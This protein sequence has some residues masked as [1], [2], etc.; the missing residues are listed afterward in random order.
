MCDETNMS[1]STTHRR[2]IV[3]PLLAAALLVACAPREEDVIDPVAEELAANGVYIFKA[4]HSG[5][6]VDITGA[7]ALAGANVQQWDCSGRTNQQFR[8]R[9]AGSGYYELRPMNSTGMCLDVFQASMVNGGNIDQWTCNG[10]TSQ[11]W[12]LVPVPAGSGKFE[13]V[14]QNSG[15]CMDVAGVSTLRGANIQQWG[16]SGHT[17]Q[18]FTFTSVVNATSP[19]AGVDTAPTCTGETDATFCGR[20]GKSCGAVTGTDNCGKPRSVASCGTCGTGQLCGV[21]TPN[22]CGPAPTT[23]LVHPGILASKAQLDFVKGH[24]GV[25]PWKTALAQAKNSR[26][27][28]LSYIPMPI[29]TVECGPYSNPDIGCGEE[30]NDVVA[31]YTHALLWYLTRDARYAQKSIEIMNAWSAVLKA[32]TNSNAPLQSAWAASVFPR[33]AEIIK[34]TYTGWAAADQARF[35]TLLHDVYLPM[36]VNG[37]G[38]N[39][40]WELAMIEATMNI[41]VFLDDR[42]LFD[43]AVGMWR[44][45]VPAYIYLT[46]DGPLPVSPPNSSKDTQSELVSFWYGQSTFVDGLGQETCRDFGH[47]QMGFASMAAA[48][49]TA[50][51]Q[52]VDLFG[53]ESKRI[54]AGWEFA[55]QY[56]NGAPVPAWL[57]GGT[58]T[59]S[60]DPTWEIAFNHYATRL[61]LAMPQSQQVIGKVRPT[62]A[63]HHMVWETLTHAATGNLGP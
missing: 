39:G 56:L 61:G 52:G 24:L 4:V 38:A 7:S 44:K 40:N 12:K 48:A 15:L 42:A 30:K 59:L 16:C 58:L 45:R 34:H 49:E 62:G 32:H 25:E 51:I 19:D 5:K 10:H 11:R 53:A 27:G 47:L 20:L 6:C 43:K 2:A 1:T 54:R 63:S 18:L 35:A 9:D 33:A 8:L 50:R 29:A 26:F 36:V 57:C 22:V 14:A 60:Y 46:T 55:A 21:A 31:A 17:N 23:N 28:S 3:L 41:A 37:S 13:L